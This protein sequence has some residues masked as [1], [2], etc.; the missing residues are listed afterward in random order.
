MEWGTAAP[1]AA[2]GRTRRPRF[3]GPRGGG[4]LGATQ[5]P[6]HSSFTDSWSSAALQGNHRF[7]RGLRTTSAAMR[8][9]FRSLPGDLD[10][11]AGLSMERNQ[12]GVRL[13]LGMASFVPIC[14]SSETY[15]DTGRHY[16]PPPVLTEHHLPTPKGQL[17]RD[18]L[19]I[20]CAPLS[21][22]H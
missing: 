21:V 7:D 3:A 18:H 2:G 17:R 12:I 5:G 13:I 9:A 15:C 14:Y 22:F 8:K 19:A 1:E 6:N 10:G 4:G 20:S 16:V 11:M